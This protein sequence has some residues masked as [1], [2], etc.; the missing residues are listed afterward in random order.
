MSHN[1][2]ATQPWPFP[3]LKHVGLEH[4]SQA[5]RL[6]NALVVADVQSYG[7]SV[8]IDGATWWDVRPMVD[9]NEHAPQAI[10]QSRMV[11]DYG[12]GVGLLV[13]HPTQQHHVQVTAKWARS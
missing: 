12:L 4:M 2:P 13:A 9:P 11:I 5:I 3:A 1:Q 7:H 6:A 10:D 8:Q